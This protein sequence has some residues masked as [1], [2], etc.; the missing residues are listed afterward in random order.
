MSNYWNEFKNG[1]DGP[2]GGETISPVSIPIQLLDMHLHRPSTKTEVTHSHKTKPSPLH[3]QELLFSMS[4][5][6]PVEPS[7]ILFQLGPMVFW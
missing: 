1:D 3:L 7:D 2:Y 6:V 4:S 5:E